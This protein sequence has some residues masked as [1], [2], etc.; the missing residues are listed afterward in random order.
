MAVPGA[1]FGAVVGFIA[2]VF[3]SGSVFGQTSRAGYHGPNGQFK[4]KEGAT[5]DKAL[6]ILATTVVGYLFGPTLYAFF[7]ANPIVGIVLALGII[8][9]ALH[10]DIEQWG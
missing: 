4:T 10:R 1:Y 6:L 8:Y 2:G 3:L 5:I 9:V 7:V